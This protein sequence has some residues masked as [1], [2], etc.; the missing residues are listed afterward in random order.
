MLYST[1][2]GRAG[3]LGNPGC[4][5]M[6]RVLPCHKRM[7]SLGEEIANSVSAGIALAI[8]L[9]ALPTLV[10]AAVRRGG[11]AAIVG[12]SVFAATVVLLYLASTLYHALPEGRAKD[13]FQ[14]I[15]HCA[16]YFL[17]AGTYT[18]FTLGVLRGAWGWTLLGLIWGLAAL[19]V[20]AKGLLGIRHPRLSVIFYLGMGWLALIA[21]R[22]L[23][24][25]LPAPGILL[26]VAGGLSYTAGVAFYAAERLRYGHF[27][28]HLFV[29]MG[30]SC[31]FFAVLWY[32]G[33]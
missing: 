29:L 25:L 3:A 9:L 21:I 22:P 7:Q 1:G 16:I 24:I 32:S 8:F 20:A 12:T 31:H 14:V 18:P 30:T 26:L 13:I 17:I 11:P 19:G 28:W 5:T 10:M 2:R 33:V 23:W 15:D 27:V 6:G 4:E